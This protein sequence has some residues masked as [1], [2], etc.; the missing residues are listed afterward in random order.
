MDPVNLELH[1]LIQRAGISHVK[2][3]YD[4]I[5]SPEFFWPY[6]G[7]NL[8]PPKTPLW[9]NLR[10]LGLEISQVTSGGDWYFLPD[11]RIASY[12]EFTG[13]K[14]SV[15]SSNKPREWYFN[16]FRSLPNPKTMNPLLIALSKVIRHA[17]SLQTIQLKSSM[18]LRSR[19]V[20]KLKIRAFDLCYKAAG[21]RGRFSDTTPLDKRR[22][23][24]EVN[25][26]R[27]DEDVVKSFED[28]LGRDGVMIYRDIELPLTRAIL[29]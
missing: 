9:P 29:F 8:V 14:D 26:W 28:A 7:V 16:E 10:E 18:N 2:L 3:L 4:C 20:K 27:P 17:S 22:M 12:A 24:W 13:E 6:D 1:K 15:E 23:I 5:I 11:E 21:V 19:Y 25:D